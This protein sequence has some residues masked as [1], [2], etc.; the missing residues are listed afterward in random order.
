MNLFLKKNEDKELNEILERTRKKSG[1]VESDFIKNDYNFINNNSKGFN[2]F[3][4][5]EPLFIG[6]RRNH[7]QNLNNAWGI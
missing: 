5:N 6:S 1:I 2:I 4:D 3:N 7:A